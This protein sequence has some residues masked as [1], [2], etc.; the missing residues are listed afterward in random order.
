MNDIERT[1]KQSVFRKSMI[2]MGFFITHCDA[3]SIII[4]T[5]V[6]QD[7]KGPVPALSVMTILNSIY[8]LPNSFIKKLDMIFQPKSVVISIEF[9]AQVQL[10]DEYFD[11]A[12]MKVIEDF[13]HSRSVHAV[14]HELHMNYLEN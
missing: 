4:S 2:G 13:R 11:A 7:A 3:Q 5:D 8:R 9:E 6:E 1:W 14:A 10:F 12:L